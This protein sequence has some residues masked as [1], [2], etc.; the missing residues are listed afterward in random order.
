V[1]QA[2]EENGMY[3]TEE[4]TETMKTRKKI[5]GLLLAVF[6]LLALVPTGAG[7]APPDTGS[8][9][10][11]KYVMPDKSTANIPGDGTT[12]V[13]IPS[14][15]QALDGIT[16]NLYKVTIGS[17]GIYPSSVGPWTPDSM[18]APTQITDS[19]GKVFA[20]T[21][22]T[23][24]SVTTAG[25]GLATTPQMPKGVYL[26]IEQASPLVTSAADPFVVALP[27]TNPAGDGFL[28]PAHVFPKNE[29]VTV[30][31]KITQDALTIG[32]IAHFTITVGIPSDIAKDTN[33]KITDIL[34]T[35]LAGSTVTVDSVIA[36]MDAAGTV[37]PTPLTSPE[38]TLATVGQTATISLNNASGSTGLTKL[39]AARYLTV[40]LSAKVTSTLATGVTASNTAT[41]SFNDKN[42]DPKTVTSDPAT[43][44]TGTIVINKV[45]AR[46][47]AALPGA[48]FKIASSPANA[49]AKQFLRIDASGNILDTTD[50]GYSTA[51]D[52]MGTTAGA[53]TTFAGIADY[54]VGADGVTKTYLKYYVVETQ[55]P[56]SY[57]LLTDPIEVAF[58]AANSTAATDY[59][60][61]QPVVNNKGFIL[62]LTGDAG[63]L[64]FTVAGVAL[65]GVAILVVVSSRKRKGAENAAK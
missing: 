52:W 4:R 58:T 16:F 27:M 31:K 15:A 47:N 45:D 62:P 51:T 14:G 18:T 1:K 54:T 53:A 26:V 48:Q 36:S 32:D 37:S 10:I 6:M 38:Y 2:S 34:P 22:A 7:A 29:K 42:G 46:T 24:A 56:A 25:G 44:H 41:L 19:T 8:L 9:V 50:T 43:F 40:Q 3:T 55:A 17:D 64:V 59:T 12:N 61:T 21:A 20:V 35:A 28:D 33:V 60:V 57:N 23:P 13:T 63:I 5:V 65:I 11:H 49:A 30:T 39:S